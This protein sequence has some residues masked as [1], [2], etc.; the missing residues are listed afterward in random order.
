MHF[1]EKREGEGGKAEPVRVFAVN[2]PFPLDTL[3]LTPPAEPSA[4]KFKGRIQQPEDF[5]DGPT[6]VFFERLE[7]YR[8]KYADHFEKYPEDNVTIKNVCN[9]RSFF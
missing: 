6:K 1:A 3:V 8:E 2:I 9:H 7:Q 4:E 5:D